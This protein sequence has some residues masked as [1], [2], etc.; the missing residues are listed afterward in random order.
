MLSLEARSTFLGL[1]EGLG[2]HRCTEYGVCMYVSWVHTHPM[3]VRHMS[4][5]GQ[6]G[7]GSSPE[8]E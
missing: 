5:V 4:V 6:S 2:T 8:E 7:H 3:N 1:F